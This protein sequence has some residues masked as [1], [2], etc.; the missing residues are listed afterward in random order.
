[1]TPAGSHC[2][3]A[4]PRANGSGQSLCLSQLRARILLPSRPEPF[5][6]GYWLLSGT[7]RWAGFALAADFIEV[8]AR[9]RDPV[10]GEPRSAGLGTFLVVKQPGLFPDG[11]TGRVIDKIGYHGFLR[12]SSL[13]KLG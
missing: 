11:M 4:Q 13:A 3:A 6:S 8:L 5:A 12:V 1:M 7:K 2:S 9:T 10:Q